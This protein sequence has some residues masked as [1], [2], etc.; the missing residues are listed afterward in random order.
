MRV[1]QQNNQKNYDYKEFVFNSLKN[2]SVSNIPLDNICEGSLAFDIG[3]STAYM[4]DK[5]FEWVEL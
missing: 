5:D 4:L 1:I 3:T 2:E